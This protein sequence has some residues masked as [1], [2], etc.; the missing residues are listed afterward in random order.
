MRGKADEQLLY[1]GLGDAQRSL[2][3]F[4]RKRTD[5]HAIFASSP[6]TLESC[7]LDVLYEI[8]ALT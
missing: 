4:F 1:F 5:G 7:R 8:S 2:A 3:H 6:G